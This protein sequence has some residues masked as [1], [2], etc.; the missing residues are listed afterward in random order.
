MRAV[1]ALVLLAAAC[2][3]KP[4]SGPAPSLEPGASA[5]PSAAAQATPRSSARA[6]SGP[7]GTSVA[8]PSNRGDD[9]PAPDLVARIPGRAPGVTG[10]EI[11]IGIETLSDTTAVFASV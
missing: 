3:S 2:S 9:V 7:A 8:A 4:S 6:T 5:V 1:W 10:K 11:K